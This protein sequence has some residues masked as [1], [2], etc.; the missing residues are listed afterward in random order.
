ML[1]KSN[2]DILLRSLLPDD[3]LIITDWP[4]YPRR[5]KELDYA[6]RKRGWLSEYFNKTDTKCYAAEHSG[7]P[8][9]FA[10]LSKTSEE[11]AEFRI[12]LKPGKT[13]SGFGKIITL[14]VLNDSFINMKI[15]RI[16]LIVRKNNPMAICLY[17]SIGF[18]ERGE[19]IKEIDGKQADFLV[20]DIYIS[21]YF[22]K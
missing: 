15:N 6:L 19:C 7:E 9:G 17:K 1:S 21:E 14:M 11:E 8:I 5:F 12:A 13:G 10:I 18:T 16:H 2:S 20:M 22:H 4:S 3:I